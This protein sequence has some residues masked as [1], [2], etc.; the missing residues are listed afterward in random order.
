MTFV[1]SHLSTATGQNNPYNYPSSPSGLVNQG[2]GA[3][4]A[5]SVVSN[6]PVDGQRNV[7]RNTSLMI[8]FRQPVKLDSVCVDSSGASC[9]CNN[10]PSCN[11]VNLA[12][13]RLFKTDLGDACTDISCP[14]VNSNETDLIVS[15]SP[16]QK[17]LTITPSS[18]LG[19]ASGN[20]Q[21]TVKFSDVIRNQNNTSMF[22]GCGVNFASWGFTVSSN[23]DLT[24]PIVS[25]ASISPLPDNS[26][27]VVGQSVP[28]VVARGSIT[29]KSK[30]NIYTPAQILS[31]SPRG[32]TVSAL[33]YSGSD[34]EFKVSVPTVN[35]AQLFTATGQ[36][37]MITN[38]DSQGRASFDGFFKLTAA[39]HPV[40]SLWDIKISPEVLADNL[41]V[42]SQVYVFATSSVNN[43]IAVPSPFNSSTLASNIEAK[44]SGLPSLRVDLSGATVTLQAKI[45]G[46]ASNNID[47][48]TTNPQALDIVPLSGGKDALSSDRIVGQPD[49]PMNTVVQVNFN[50]PIN[51]LTVDGSAD[52]VSKYIQIVNATASSSPAG[53]VC[54]S[55]SQCL[56]YKC[57]NSVCVGNYLGGNFAVSNNYQTVEF[58]SD[59]ECGINA[60]GQKIYCLP[61]D[62]HLAVKLTAANLKTCQSNSDCLID[63]SYNSCVA[64]ALGYSTC[65][66]AAGQNY[67][68][69]N[70]NNLDGIVDASLNSLDGNRNGSAEGPISFFNDNYSTSSPQNTGK[71]DKYLWSFYIGNKLNLTPPY[72]TKIDPAPGTQGLAVNQPINVY[73]NELMMNSSLQTGS[74]TVTSGT[75]TIQH[76]L[77]NLNTLTP[78]PLGYWVT[79][80]NKDLPPYDGTPDITV[81]QID[82][83]A[84][85]QSASFKAEVGSGVRDIYQ[86]CYK[87]SSGPDCTATPDQPSCCFGQATSTLGANGNC[88]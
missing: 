21:Y 83:S 2:V 60:C 22:S 86:N 19:S 78:T 37:L 57:E 34:S 3:I 27:D 84:F 82:H 65:Q 20:T 13:V 23:L 54:S 71:K 17:T 11:Q 61:P 4:G 73:F 41:K 88:Q 74:V 28:A 30:P 44:L 45:A 53:A 51:P 8:T 29:V 7:P 56:S 85:P 33:S 5:C 55:N 15:V 32:A 67:P 72:I 62:S 9:A 69:A 58:T 47:V 43:S 10:T 76:K 25:P 75:S 16:D 49:K 68:E 24:P 14:S 42:G 6:Y 79:A 66:N 39:N 81:A 40:G 18:Y 52:Q 1:I 87:P 48:T 70:I 36:P 31:I 50:K 64:T 63:G 26:A 46:S 77:I 59:Q 12:A 38:F 80:Y 35:Q